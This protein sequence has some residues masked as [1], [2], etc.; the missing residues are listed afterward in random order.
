MEGFYINILDYYV[1]NKN[2]NKKLNQN[3]DNF[4]TFNT[5]NLNN[6]YDKANTSFNSIKSDITRGKERE[7]EKK[8]KNILINKNVL[9][10]HKNSPY[11]KNFVK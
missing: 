11:L 10:R 8:V 4:I 2:P 6:S 9:T 1:N 7:I 5:K 3:Q